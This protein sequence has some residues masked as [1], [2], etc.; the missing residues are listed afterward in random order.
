M[1]LGP[2]SAYKARLNGKRKWF[3]TWFVYHKSSY[4]SFAI[5]HLPLAAPWLQPDNRG[6]PSDRNASCRPTTTRA[7][8]GSV[9]SDAAEAGH[10]LTVELAAVTRDMLSTRQPQN[11]WRWRWI[12]CRHRETWD[13]ETS[14][15]AISRA[16]FWI[17][18]TK[19][20]FSQ[21]SSKQD[22]HQR[23]GSWN[24]KVS[25]ISYQASVE[26]CWNSIYHPRNLFHMPSRFSCNK[27]PKII[28]I[29]S[30]RLGGLGKRQSEFVSI[31]WHQW[32]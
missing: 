8:M 9:R 2:Q 31:T 11:R 4:C 1:T 27:T 12:T 22:S 15:S 28:G 10:S 19:S 18:W 14:D 6:S 30:H 26:T 7:D 16:F 25:C 20:Y 29:P 32:V 21:T 13:R 3:H 23:V 17:L 5:H 24:R